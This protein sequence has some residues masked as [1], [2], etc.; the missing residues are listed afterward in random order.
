MNKVSIGFEGGGGIAVRLDDDQLS[1]LRSALK[2][3]DKWHELD[4]ADGTVDV[5]LSEVNYV[6]TDSGE[7]KV[8]FRG[9]GG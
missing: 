5:K 6:S 1:K 8:G 2:G 3:G 7:H 9:L 4:T